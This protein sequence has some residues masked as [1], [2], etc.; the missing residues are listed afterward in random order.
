[1]LLRTTDLAFFIVKLIRY[2]VFDVTGVDNGAFNKTVAS[3]TTLSAREEIGGFEKTS[4]S[5]L[6]SGRYTRA[7]ADKVPT[8]PTILLVSLFAVPGLKV[9]DAPE[10]ALFIMA[11]LSGSR[12]AV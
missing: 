3:G 11:D 2:G 8:D 9:M 5:A 10:Y 7:A 4:R 6:P 1:L 12:T